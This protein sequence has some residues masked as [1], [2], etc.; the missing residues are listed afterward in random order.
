MLITPY[1]M[2]AYWAARRESAERCADRLYRMFSELSA[3]DQPM[4]TWYEQAKSRKKSPARRVDFE[5]R[6]YL[7][8]LVNRGR[9][10][11]DDKE[12]VEELG[13][14][15]S[16]SNGGDSEK[17]ATMNVTCGSYSEWVGNSVTLNLPE[18]LG[19]LGQSGRMV[20]VLA[21]V[22]RAWEPEW[23]GVMSRD[24][25]NTRGFDAKHPFI[26]WLL[27]LSN[28]VTPQIPPLPQSAMVQQV[29]GVGWIIVVGDEPP[30]FATPEH[31][32]SIKQVEVLLK[33]TH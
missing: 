14:L 20:C 2:G 24:A 26:D 3:C 30:A 5:D 16:F 1:F 32:R 10:R 19:N 33:L 17:A 25:M 29:D 23:A 11:N 31:L 27:Y 7:L 8:N 4:T 22:A 21:A 18:S 28:S 13:Y 9:H 6:E 15:M 12:Q